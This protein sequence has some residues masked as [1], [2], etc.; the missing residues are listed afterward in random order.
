MEYMAK[1]TLKEPRNLIIF[2][3]ANA[4]FD[5]LIILQVKI[6]HM[7]LNDVHQAGFWF[8][9]RIMVDMPIRTLRFEH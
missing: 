4:M 2:T 3:T 1:D 8:P 7:I 5:P 9:V 6:K